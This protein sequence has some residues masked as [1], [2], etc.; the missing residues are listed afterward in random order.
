MTASLQTL[1]YLAKHPQPLEMATNDVAPI[2]TWTPRD[3]A[4]SVTSLAAF[5]H[6]VRHRPR[7]RP[8]PRLRSETQT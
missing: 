7:P 6:K 2:G 4:M 1:R 5:M 8:R 3:V